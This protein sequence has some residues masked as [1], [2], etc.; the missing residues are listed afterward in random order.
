MGPKLLFRKGPRFWG[1]ASHQAAAYTAGKRAATSENLVQIAWSV[2]QANANI[3]YN[4]PGDT[5]TRNPEICLLLPEL[6][7]CCVSRGTSMSDGPASNTE[8]C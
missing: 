8:L 2:L 6:L 1:R 7:Q 5:I 3:S 4:Y